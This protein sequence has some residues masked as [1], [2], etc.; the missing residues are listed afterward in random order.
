MVWK[1]E[2]GIQAQLWAETIRDFGMVQYSLF[3]KLAGLV[4]RAWN[5][6][7]EWGADPYGEGYTE[8]LGT[9]NA[10]MVQHEMPFLASQDVKFRVP[11]PGIR[12][13]EGMLLLNAPMPGAALRYTLDGSEPDEESPLWSEPVPCNASVV[14]ARLF[15]MGRESVTSLYTAAE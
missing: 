8:A 14:K 5:S 12:I 1:N 6:M 13:A 10:K 3:P 9:F 11:Q 15:Y 4:E 7:P 2:K